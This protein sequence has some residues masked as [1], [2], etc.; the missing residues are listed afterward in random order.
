M[1]SDAILELWNSDQGLLCLVSTNPLPTTP[2]NPVFISIITLPNQVYSA[3][4]GPLYE[5]TI[6]R[7]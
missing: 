2:P 3:G 5:G 6:D 1:A 4:E 7:G